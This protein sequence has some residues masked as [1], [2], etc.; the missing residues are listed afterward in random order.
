MATDGSTTNG[1]RPEPPKKDEDD[2][3]KKRSGQIK[4]NDISPI[5]AADIYDEVKITQLPYPM[6]GLEPVISQEL[7]E[8]HYGKHH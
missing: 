3:K 6:N 8:Y 7:M 5:A 4:M 1:G 2:K